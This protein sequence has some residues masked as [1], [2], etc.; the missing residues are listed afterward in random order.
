V[1]VYLITLKIPDIGPDRIDALSERMVEAKNETAALK[2]VL[3]DSVTVDRLS[4][5]DAVRLGAQG[6]EIEQARS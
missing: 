1:P 4:T 3:A 5:A 6:H 2:H